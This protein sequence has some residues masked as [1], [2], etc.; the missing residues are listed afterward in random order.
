MECCLIP[1]T[2]HSIGLTHSILPPTKQRDVEIELLLRS[3]EQF[4]LALVTSYAAYFGVPRRVCFEKV[5]DP[6]H[7]TGLQINI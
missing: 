6:V 4:H 3:I 2:V 5:Y 7:H 1:P